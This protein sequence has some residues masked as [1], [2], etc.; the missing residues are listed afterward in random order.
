MAT[1][2]PVFVSGGSG[3]TQP[4]SKALSAM[5]HSMDLMVTGT[6]MMFSVQAASHGAGQM[7]P[8]HFGEVVGRVQVLRR[9]VP[10]GV[11]D[12]VVPVGDLVVH[13][14]AGVTIG[15]AAIHAARGLAR[16]LRLARRDDELAVM[17]D[18]VGGR[19]V[20]PVLAFDLEKARDLAH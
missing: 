4:S 18:A 10:V 9:H 12:E 3:V 15:D 6:S 7:R 2:L 19:L 14:A 8:G 1:R 17:A 13:R 20:G 5:A 11:V 16:D